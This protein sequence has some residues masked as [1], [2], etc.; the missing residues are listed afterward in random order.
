MEDV[1][2]RLESEDRRLSIR[3]EYP[4]TGGY[5]P[6]LPNKVLSPMTAHQGHS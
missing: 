1:E 6:E 5:A 3:P 4:L 2:Y